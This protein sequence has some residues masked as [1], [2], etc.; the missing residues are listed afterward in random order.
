MDTP[1]ITKSNN[2]QI[3][4]ISVGH[5]VHDLY[6]SFLAPLLP[7]L[8]DNLSISLTS[9]G[10]LSTF[11]RI[12]SVINPFVGYLADKIG[13][14]YFVIFAPAITATLMSLLGSL[15]SY[16][17]L[18]LLLFCAGISSTLF[19]ASSPG[20][21]AKA[22]DNKKGYGLSIYMA[23]GGLGRSLGPLIAVWAVSIWGLNGVYRLMV[24][25]W[26]TSVY[27]YFQFKDL[28]TTIH[29]KPS[30][31]SALPLFRRFFLPLSIVVIL[32]STLIVALSTYLP[33]YLVQSG[34]PLWIAGAGLSVIEISG[35]IGALF[36]GPLSDKLGRRKSINLSMILSALFVPVFLQIQGWFLFPILVL[37]GIFSFSPG[38]L[39]LALVQ[40]H[41][42][43]HRSTGNGVY[44]F[45][46]FLSNGLMLIIIGAI[47]DYFGLRTAYL[48]GAAASLA[49]IPALTLLPSISK[50]KT[51][52]SEG[53]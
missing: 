32:R 14:R 7:T 51:P 20:L 19:H 9:A 47:G 35:V 29:D 24:L 8:I 27:L 26:V 16:S 22:A 45:I 40:D 23:G 39:F 17:S 46:H 50:N 10:I 3:L 11:I 42:E 37:L 6:S 21:V 38:T 36:I 15:T 1:R 41:F 25:G 53:V 34:S 5:S 4:G 30:L 18:A 33:I 31:K 44:L 12:P 43:D 49:S 13:A 48:I 52:S 2:R 28:D